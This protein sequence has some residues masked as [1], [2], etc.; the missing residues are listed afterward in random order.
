[1]YPNNF[2]K[3]IVLLSVYILVSLLVHFQCLVVIAIT[4]DS[5]LGD[6]VV[7][8]SAGYGGGKGGGGEGGGG[9]GKVGGRG[10]HG[11]GGGGG[12][13]GGKGGGGGF[14]GK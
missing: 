12:H 1:M 11:G 4:L 6:L 13:S 14:K 2:L 3:N 5:I 10:G 9:G 8:E 7:A